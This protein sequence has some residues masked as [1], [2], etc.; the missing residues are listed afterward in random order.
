MS[1]GLTAAQLTQL[2]NR[3][4][5]PA[6]F[7][8]LALS[9][10][11]YVWS[12]KGDTTVLG[13]TFKG[14]GEHGIIQGIESDRTLKQQQISLS[15]AGVPATYIA[16]GV[17]AATRAV[18]YQGKALTVYLG[19]CN[20]DTGVPLADPTA[21]WSGFA[22]VMTFQLGQTITCTLTGEHYSSLLRRPNGFTM[23]T[24]SHQ[25]RVG[26][27]DTFFDPQSLLSGAPKPLL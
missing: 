18:R 26:A 15:L 9:P 24:V 6:Y 11:V 2:A 14:V 7:V 4:K 8:T 19:F 10:V 21:I 3:V 16:A 13:Q 25:Q 1:R 22:D 5:S 20:T 23:T 12:G 27:T 17:I